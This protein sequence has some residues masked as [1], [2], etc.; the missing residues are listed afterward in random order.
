MTVLLIAFVG[1]LQ[2]NLAS[3]DTFEDCQ[4]YIPEVLET[5]D[6]VTH[7]GCYY[8]TDEDNNAFGYY[9]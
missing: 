5:N 7:V 1:S 8:K 4:Q 2:F 3:Y 6:N 9:V